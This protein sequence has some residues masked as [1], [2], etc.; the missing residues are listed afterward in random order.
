MRVAVK[1][2]WRTPAVAEPRRGAWSRGVG[3]EGVGE[4][5]SLHLREGLRI[6]HVE[7]GAD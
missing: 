1:V 2:A 4:K 3:E 7:G 5:P 6:D